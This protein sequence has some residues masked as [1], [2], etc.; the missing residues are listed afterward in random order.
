M[1][2]CLFL[3]LCSTPTRLPCLRVLCSHPTAIW[4]QEPTCSTSLVS[5]KTL[6]IVDNCLAYSDH[7]ETH[8]HRWS[9]ILTSTYAPGPIQR[10]GRRGLSGE[11]ARCWPKDGPISRS[12]EMQGDMAS[13]VRYFIRAYTIL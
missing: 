5:E 9:D 1:F 4:C 10:S 13:L 6:L 8:D 3:S 7:V 12:S 2:P 11:P